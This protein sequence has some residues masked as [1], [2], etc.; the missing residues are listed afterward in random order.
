MTK[1][2]FIYERLRFL[3]YRFYSLLDRVRPWPSFGLFI[4]GVLMKIDWNKLNDEQKKEIIKVVSESLLFLTCRKL[5]ID[6]F[7]LKKKG[8]I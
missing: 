5:K 3:V 6:Y 2:D 4:H 7:D 8:I 1:G